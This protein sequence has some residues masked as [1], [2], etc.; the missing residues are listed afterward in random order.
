MSF[1][2]VVLAASL[3]LM[4]TATGGCRGTAVLAP[5]VPSHEAR[6]WS[7]VTTRDLLAETYYMRGLSRYRARQLGSAITEF[8]I[9][10]ELAP[11]HRMARELLG[12]LEWLADPER[13]GEVIDK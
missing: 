13:S 2:R 6:S 10:L 9:A 4:S 8:R 5:P 12:K 11:S 1:G 7:S 3:L